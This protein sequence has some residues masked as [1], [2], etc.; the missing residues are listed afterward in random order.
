[1]DSAEGASD[2]MKNRNGEKPQATQDNTGMAENSDGD[3]FS[4][5]VILDY[6]MAKGD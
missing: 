5:D 3:A 4:E 2:E 6:E 1:M